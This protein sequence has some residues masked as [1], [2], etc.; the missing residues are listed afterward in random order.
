MNAQYDRILSAA[1]QNRPD[2]IHAMVKE[3]SCPPGHGNQVGQTALHIA[4]LWGHREA[5]AALIELG[6]PVNAQNRMGGSTP[7]HMAVSSS[8]EPFSNRIECA[9]MLIAAGA[10]PEIADF[11]YGKASGSTP[12]DTLEDE[13][14]SGML[15]DDDNVQELR[16]VLTGG[17]GIQRPALF[18][19]ID[20]DDLESIK[21]LFEESTEGLVDVDRK[22]GLTPLQYAVDK[23]LLSIDHDSGEEGQG[24]SS[25][26]LADII[27]ALLKHGADANASIKKRVKRGDDAS[28]LLTDDGSDKPLHKLCLE[29][30]TLYA[31]SS[32]DDDIIAKGAI[33]AV[34][35][36]ASALVK[37]GGA[38]PEKA[39]MLLLH[40]ACRRGNLRMVQFLI[41]VVGVD[42][43]HRGRQGLTP[44]RFGARSGRA[45]I[46]EW[47]LSYKGVDG[48]TVDTTIQDDR[49]KT[50]LDAARANYKADIVALLEEVTA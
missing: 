23:L 17:G 30:T 36:V 6:A 29:L 26:K 19:L 37:I 34:E 46:V 4:C 44:L 25:K 42:I 28:M 33:D 13:V 9:R 18:D 24:H 32:S 40:D 41:E 39:T 3:M 20:V 11:G 12:L 16:M 35:K 2:V 50:A 48:I 7:L 15:Q 47:L 14:E 8:K 22:T 43:N 31:S 10:D 1:Q 5:V 21:T 45:E 38:K 27:E 49:G